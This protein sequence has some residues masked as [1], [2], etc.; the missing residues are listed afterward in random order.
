MKLF[1]PTRIGVRTSKWYLSNSDYCGY[2]IT[3]FFL[4][5]RSA[6]YFLKLRIFTLSNGIILKIGGFYVILRGSFTTI[7]IFER[8]NYEKYLVGKSFI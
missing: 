7:K 8:R 6:F 2:A 1:Q 4:F 3:H 5:E